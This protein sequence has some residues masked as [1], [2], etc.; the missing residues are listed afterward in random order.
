MTI[1]RVELQG[2]IT[3]SHDFTNIKHHEDNKGAV[4]QTHIARSNEAAAEVKLQHV[5]DTEETDN[6]QKKFD[7]KEEGSNQYSGDGGNRRNKKNDNPDGKVVLKA[8]QHGFDL[9]I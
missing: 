6:R 4:L 7:A 1:S 5:N 9:K 3:N 8:P 2:Q